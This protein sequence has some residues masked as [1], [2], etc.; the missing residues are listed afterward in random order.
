MKATGEFTV[1]DWKEDALQGQWEGR[2]LSSVTAVF[3]ASG[4][5]QGR[6]LVAYL[7]SYSAIDQEDPHNGTAHYTGYLL[8][9]GSIGE[10]QGTLVLEDKGVFA[11]HA[12]SSTLTAVK[13]SG[14]GGLEGLVG[15]GRYYSADGTMAI[16][17][18]LTPTEADKG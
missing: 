11:A 16:E 15:T 8:F 6:F 17:L 7:M 9:E 14:T 2:Q 1:S 13:G 3:E 12:P 10:K 5:I 4:A 18:D